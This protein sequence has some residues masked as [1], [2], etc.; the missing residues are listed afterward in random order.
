MTD[1]RNWMHRIDLFGEKVF[2]WFT[3]DINTQAH[4]TVWCVVWVS[5][6]K[7]NWVFHPTSNPMCAASWA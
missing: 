6:R 1:W 3:S 2:P 5:V 7:E 4:G